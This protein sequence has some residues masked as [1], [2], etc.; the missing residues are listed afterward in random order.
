MRQETGNSWGSR[1]GADRDNEQKKHNDQGRLRFHR[2]GREGR[3]MRRE[4]EGKKRKRE[5]RKRKA[6]EGRGLNSRWDQARLWGRNMRGQRCVQVEQAG[7]GA[8]EAP[9]RT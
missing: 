8:W 6:A 7:R 2:E 9:L 1:L 4:G 3:G 5:R